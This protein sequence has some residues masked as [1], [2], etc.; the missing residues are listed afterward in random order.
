MDNVKDRNEFGNLLNS[1]CLEGNG[2]EIGVNCGD[3][4]EILL[5]T[6][7]LRK[8]YLLDIWKELPY[9]Q[10]YDITNKAQDEQDNKYYMVVE[11]MKQYGER[12]E[13]IRKDCSI[14]YSDFEDGFFDFIYID[15]NHKYEYVKN[16]IA[17][18]YPKLKT[19]GLFAGHD[20]LDGKIGKTIFGVKKAVDEFCEAINKKATI[21]T[22]KPCP[23]WYF[24]K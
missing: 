8:I 19:N 7:K 13:I 9:E 14:A 16:D 12:V 20:Y 1:L 23:S 4:S 21:T 3:Y 11:K 5:N 18:W 17:N 15:A 24:I 10:Y 22:E 2:I 6:S